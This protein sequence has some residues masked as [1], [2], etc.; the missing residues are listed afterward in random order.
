VDVIVDVDVEEFGRACEG[1]VCTRGAGEMVPGAMFNFR[2]N[3]TRM[4]MP[5]ASESRH[6]TRMQREVAE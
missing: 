3:D 1:D 2:T 6:R 4:R 5:G